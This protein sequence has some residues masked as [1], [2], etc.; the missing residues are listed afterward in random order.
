MFSRY[1]GCK[2]FL[3]GVYEKIW[4]VPIR[5]KEVSNGAR[6]KWRMGGEMLKWV[7]LRGPLAQLLS[8]LA[9]GALKGR[10]KIPLSK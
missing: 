5:N 3:V 10:G 1:G 9:A 6:E 7:V 8:P 2:D 4:V